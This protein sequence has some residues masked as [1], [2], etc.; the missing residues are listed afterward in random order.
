[1]T[2]QYPHS[3]VYNDPLYSENLHAG[4]RQRLWE[5]TAERPALRGHSTFSGVTAGAARQ[6]LS[7]PGEFRR[8]RGASRGVAGA[9]RRPAGFGARRGRFPSS[10]PR[11]RYPIACEADTG[12]RGLRDMASISEEFDNLF[13]KRTFAHLSTLAPHSMPVWVDY[14][15]DANRMLVNTARG[16]HLSQRGSSAVHGGRESRQLFP[17]GDCTCWHVQSGRTCDSPATGGRPILRDRSPPLR[18]DGPVSPGP[19]VGSVEVSVTPCA[20][21]LPGVDRG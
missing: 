21:P 1:M 18:L 8:C 10:A 12:G 7:A 5:P 4:R 2:K 15:A 11:A 3:S 14:N 13:E 9:G 19:E 20:S 6:F 16:R 17:L